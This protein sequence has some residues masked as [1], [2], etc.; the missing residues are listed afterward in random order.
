MDIGL[1]QLLTLLALLTAIAAA[2][3]KCPL[4]VSVV[5]LCLIELLQVWR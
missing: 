1:L 3:T 2:A 4:W 5:L